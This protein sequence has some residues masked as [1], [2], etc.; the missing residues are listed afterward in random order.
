MEVRNERQGA[1]EAFAPF[2]ILGPVE[3]HEGAPVQADDP[4]KISIKH[5]PAD[6]SDPTERC[7]A[8]PFT[9]VFSGAVWNCRFL[10][11]Y[12]FHQPCYMHLANTQKA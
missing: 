2:A 5:Y 6:G 7:A 4:K 11:V 12:E 9:G 8:Y 10:Y 3:Q 1:R